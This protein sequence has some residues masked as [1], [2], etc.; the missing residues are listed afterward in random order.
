MPVLEN[1]RHSIKALNCSALW[2]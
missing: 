1:H 2:R